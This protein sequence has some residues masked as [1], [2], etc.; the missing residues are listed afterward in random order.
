MSGVTHTFYLDKI[1]MSI[2]KGAPYHVIL[3]Q[4]EQAGV[5]QSLSRSVVPSATLAK[6][7]KN[8]LAAAN[9]RF[10][11]FK[12]WV[13]QQ[14]RDSKDFLKGKELINQ[15]LAGSVEHDMV[16]WL[17]EVAHDKKNHKEGTDLRKACKLTSSQGN[18][19]SQPV[20]QGKREGKR[21]GSREGEAKVASPDASRWVAQVPFAVTYVVL[22]RM[23]EDA[24]KQ[25]EGIVPIKST[26]LR[27]KLTTNFAEALEAGTLTLHQQLSLFRILGPERV[28]PKSAIEINNTQINKSNKIVVVH[29]KAKLAP[30]N[31]VVSEKGELL[32]VGGEYGNIDKEGLLKLAAEGTIEEAKD[33]KEGLDFLDSSGI[34]H[35]SRVKLPSGRKEEYP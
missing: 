13:K 15:I 18:A 19:S 10:D 31:L 14:P 16:K 11:T 2:L 7:G 6:L 26:D 20:H 35:D 3:Q 17:N 4:V 5:M 1:K 33:F 27:H 34:L 8:D 12:E 22:A 23:Q 9:V 21:E 28:E 32:G 29:D 25:R 24:A 30:S